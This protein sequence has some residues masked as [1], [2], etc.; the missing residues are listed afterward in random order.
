MYRPIS[1]AH[2]LLGELDAVPTLERARGSD[3][4]MPQQTSTTA[5]TSTNQNFDK[6]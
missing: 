6:N 5:G 3:A 4:A 2:R 1:I